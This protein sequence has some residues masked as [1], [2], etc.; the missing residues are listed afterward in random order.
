M[1]RIT[2]GFM[3]DS[4]G[5]I[6][7]DGGGRRDGI[8]EPIRSGNGE[9]CRV[10]RLRPLCA[11][12]RPSELKPTKTAKTQPVPG[13]NGCSMKWIPRATSWEAWHLV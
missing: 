2:P 10:G 8:L 6:E 13:T 3:R 7:K 12:P 5:T 9:L 11:P 1:N 4:V